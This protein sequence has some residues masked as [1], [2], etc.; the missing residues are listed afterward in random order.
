[1]VDLIKKE[2]TSLNKR[3]YDIS[4]SGESVD[5]FKDLRDKIKTLYPEVYEYIVFKAAKDKSELNI[6]RSNYLIVLHKTL[7][8][9]NEMRNKEML[10]EERVAKLEEL[11]NK[12]RFELVPLLTI[13]IGMMLIFWALHT[14]NPDAAKALIDLFK[15]V[16]KVITFSV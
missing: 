15:H 6:L 5:E 4:S 3:V 13:L 9:V 10:L 8:I 2:I 14:I 16:I 1:M 12:K 11:S 7:D